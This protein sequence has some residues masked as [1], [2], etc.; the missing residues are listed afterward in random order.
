M[1][2]LL[3][4]LAALAW[5]TLVC[6]VGYELVEKSPSTPLGPLPGYEQARRA[7][8]LV[9]FRATTGIGTVDRLLHEGQE[10]VVYYRAL[11][12]DSPAQ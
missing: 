6:L 1:R 7:D 2:R 10:A 3:T 4:L 9:R 11:A 8:R 5:V 12:G